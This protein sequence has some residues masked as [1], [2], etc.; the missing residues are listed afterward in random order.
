MHMDPALPN[1]VLITLVILFIGLVLRLA[2][3]P[4]VMGYILAGV[5]LGSSGLGVI[6]D[7][8]LIARMGE[9]GVVLLLFFI[10]MEVVPEKLFSSWKISVVGTIVQIILSV[11]VV[12]ILGWSLDWSLARIILIGF[13]ISLSS[14]AVVLNILND[15][16][17]LNTPIG[18]DV[19]GVL[20]VQ[21]LA[22]IVML[23]I[24]TFLTGQE[25]SAAHIAWQL[26]GAL[27][28]G[29]LALFIIIKKVIHFPIASWIKKDHELQIF[30]A[31]VICFGL[32]Y[33]SAIFEL[34]TALGAFLGGM[35]IGRAKETQW[36]HNSLE[37]FRVIFVAFFFLSIGLLFD[38]NFLIQNV[39]LI[40][41]V[42]VAVFLTN[43]LIN[44]AVMRSLGY[45]WSN[46]IY[47]GVLLSQV[48]E[49][50]FVLA[51]IGRQSEMISLFAHKLIIAVISITL[52]MSPILVKVTKKLLGRD[53]LSLEDLSPEQTSSP[54][55]NEK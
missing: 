5:V 31:L 28:M 34:S 43:G 48:G 4:H 19:L 20:L 18:Q 35:L 7:S 40:F 22:I 9:Y 12:A 51:A 10:G 37:P 30:S 46:G 3:Q 17:E 36:F 1:I 15:S 6:T 38:I 23:I 8:S 33:F 26:L 2:R 45:S 13:V 16:N 49:F 14:T 42:V 11:T 39:G 25:V 47:A 27:L 53:A 55:S 29:G 41:L 21:D 32:A 50:S 54:K 52:L 24:L 44:I